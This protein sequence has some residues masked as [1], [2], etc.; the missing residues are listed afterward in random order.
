M[1]RSPLPIVYVASHGGFHSEKH[2]LGG[3]ATVSQQLVKAWSSDPAISLTL[4]SPSSQPHK[5]PENIRYVHLPVL[6]NNVNPAQL[7]RRSYARFCR[8]FEKATTSYL[9]SLQNQWSSPSSFAVLSNDICEGINFKRVAA[10]GIPITTIFHV[11]VVDFFSRIYLGTKKGPPLRLVKFFRW[12]EGTYLAKLFPDVLRLVFEKQASCIRY[13]S[14]IV[15]PSNS[16]QHVLKRCYPDDIAG[17]TSIVPW[18]S[19]EDSTSEI[20]VKRET[21]K[22]IRDFDLRQGTTILLTMS[23]ISPE[24]GIERLLNALLL[25]EKEIKEGRNNY[26]HSYKPQNVRVLICGSAAFMGGK[27][28][29]AKIKKTASKLQHVRVAFPG[30]VSGAKKRALFQLADLFISPSLHESYGLSL[31][32]ALRHGIP[33]VSS[34]TYGAL[35]ISNKKTGRIVDMEGKHGPLRLLETIKEIIGNTEELRTMKKEA[36]HAGRFMDFETSARTLKEIIGR[37]I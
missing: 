25:W 28:Y 37:T 21:E 4:L 1:N 33:T 18:G 30:Q 22:A 11:D 6:K 12:A 9:E 26:T 27:R 24:K 29:A 2:P 5:L 34:T 23:R 7:N 10:M 13:S 35:Q 3:G 17:K 14:K 19:W 32:E 31:V 20:E 16:M 8:R 15:V 36:L